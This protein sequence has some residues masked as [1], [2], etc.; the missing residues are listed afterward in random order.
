MFGL[1]LGHFSQVQN[2]MSK[3]Q[4]FIHDKF[5]FL[6]DRH[7]MQYLALDSTEDINNFEIICV[8]NHIIRILF[9]FDRGHINMTVKSLLCNSSAYSIWLLMEVLTR[10]DNIWRYN[11]D[12]LPSENP[13][14]ENNFYLNK[15]VENFSSWYDLFSEKNCS[16]TIIG[17]DNLVAD[18]YD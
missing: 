1:I 6:V 8:E 5:G 4:K 14:I 2:R 18:I 17:L 9:E 7:G 15:V 3:A 13:N 11:L 12:K 10:E 16:S